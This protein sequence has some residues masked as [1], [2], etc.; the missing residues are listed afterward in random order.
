MGGILGKGV[1]MEKGAATAIHVMLHER[2]EESEAFMSLL[3][4]WDNSVSPCAEVT[5]VEP[6]PCILSLEPPLSS[7]PLIPGPEG[8]AWLWYF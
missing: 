7:G 1:E 8:L 6:A 5:R 4:T 3:V 2:W